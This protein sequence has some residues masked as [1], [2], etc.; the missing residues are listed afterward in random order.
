[1]PEKE[2]RMHYKAHGRCQRRVRETEREGKAIEMKDCKEQKEHARVKVRSLLCAKAERGREEDCALH[3]K[4]VWDVL[5][6]STSSN[7]AYQSRESIVNRMGPMTKTA[8]T[9]PS[10]KRTHQ[11]TVMC[12]SP[13]KD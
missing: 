2:Y 13:T 5:Q 10:P 9:K 12:K 8:H 7:S 1:M 6:Q 4:A 3:T 11:S